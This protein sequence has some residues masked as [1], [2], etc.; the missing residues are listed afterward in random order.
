MDEKQILTGERCLDYK[1]IFRLNSN[2][3]T[4]HLVPM[5]FTYAYAITTHKSQGS[6]WPNVL[7][8]EENFPFEKEEHIRWLYTACTRSEKKLV[9]VK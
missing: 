6:S 9:L 3:K 4:A 7:I 2:M 8:L 1:K 5:E